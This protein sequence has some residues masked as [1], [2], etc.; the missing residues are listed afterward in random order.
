M[1]QRLAGH[2]QYVIVPYGSKN[3][4]HPHATN[5]LPSKKS[6][7]TTLHSIGKLIQELL[8]F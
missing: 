7:M 6:Y 3:F 5:D 4:S 1:K 8:K 2:E